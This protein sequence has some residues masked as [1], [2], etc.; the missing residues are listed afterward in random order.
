MSID[1][2]IGL[3]EIFSLLLEN[4][5]NKFLSWGKDTFLRKRK[6][7]NYSLMFF[8]EMRLYNLSVYNMDNEMY[9]IITLSSFNYY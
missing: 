9:N 4:G 3:T 5:R 6:L 7:L 8:K 1:F 2:N